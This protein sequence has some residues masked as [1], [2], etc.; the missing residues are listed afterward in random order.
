[1]NIVYDLYNLTPVYT[2]GWLKA[3]GIRNPY[4]FKNYT[5]LI[6]KKYLETDFTIKINEGSSLVVFLDDSEFNYYEVVHA[7]FGKTKFIRN[8]KDPNY[9]YRYRFN[10]EAEVT[11]CNPTVTDYFNDFDKLKFTWTHIS[12]KKL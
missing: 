6:N 7:Y 2:I 1:M 10:L 8:T 5:D 3:F 11:V 9:P 4:F 12:R